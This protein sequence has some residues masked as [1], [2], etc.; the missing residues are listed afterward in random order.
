M[1]NQDKDRG[2]SDTTQGIRRKNYSQ[3]VSGGFRRVNGEI[4]IKKFLFTPFAT[5][6]E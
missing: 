4:H 1:K 3:L 6:S 2:V 5:Q